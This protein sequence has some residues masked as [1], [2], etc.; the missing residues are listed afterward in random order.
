VGVDAVADRAYHGGM[1]HLPER[2]QSIAPTPSVWL[3]LGAVA[4]VMAVIWVVVGLA[5]R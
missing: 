3:A 5:A 1:R 4:V 2:H